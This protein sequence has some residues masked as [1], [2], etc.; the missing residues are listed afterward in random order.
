LI[1]REP[2]EPKWIKGARI[3]L[4]ERLTDHRPLER[5]EATPLRVH[6]VE[7]LRESVR[8]EVSR[9]LNTRC[10]VREDRNG[11]VIDYGLPDFSWMSAASGENRQQLADIIARKVAAFE[12]RLAQVRVTLARDAT[13]PRALTG[14]IEALLVVESIRE[15]VSFPLAFYTK[16]GAAEVALAPSGGPSHGN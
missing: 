6:N 13:D 9:L 15:P 3:P 4:F 2:S 16:T 14:T 7:E 12:P 10:P 1:V 8:L 11:T 5:T